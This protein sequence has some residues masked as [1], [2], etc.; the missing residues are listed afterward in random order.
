MSNVDFQR[1]VNSTLFI[2]AGASSGSITVRVIGDTQ[3]ESDEQFFVNLLSPVVNA[4]IATGQASGTIVN[5]TSI[6]IEFATYNFSE[7]VGNAQVH[8]K[9]TGDTTGAS[10]MNFSTG[11]NSFFACTRS[12][13]QRCRTATSS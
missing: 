3:L 2:P 4:T 9:R 12:T 13:G 1:V 10:S 5:D 11:G 7:G 6:Q 8:V